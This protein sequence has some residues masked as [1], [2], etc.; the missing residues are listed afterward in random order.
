MTRR[1][2]AAVLAACAGCSSICEREPSPVVTA[3]SPD[4]RNEIRLYEAPLSVEVLRDGVQVVGR[5]RIG[6]LVDGCHLARD[7]RHRTVADRSGRGG[8]T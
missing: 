8:P 2:L 4:G 3:V 1:I 6:L 5:S 7:N